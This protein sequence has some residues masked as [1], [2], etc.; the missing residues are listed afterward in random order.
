MNVNIQAIHFNIY[1]QLTRFVEKKAERIARRNPDIVDFTV[2]FRLIK[3]DEALNKE[4]TL[5]VTLPAG[6]EIVAVKT[7]PTFEES[8]DQCVEA[9]EHQVERKTGKQDR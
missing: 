2:N 8:F 9:I 4:C 7:C 3:H 6:G 1:G 5:K